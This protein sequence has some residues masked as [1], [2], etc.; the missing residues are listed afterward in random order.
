[1]PSI[2]DNFQSSSRMNLK[3]NSSPS[4][5]DNFN[6]SRSSISR[7]ADTMSSDRISS[8]NKPA[9]RTSGIT[10][11]EKLYVLTNFY[12]MPK[13][14]EPRMAYGKDGSTIYN[15]IGEGKNKY[16]TRYTDP[17]TGKTETSFV[18]KKDV[19]FDLPDV[20]KK[21]I[22]NKYANFIKSYVEDQN[23][24]TEFQKK[25]FESQSGFEKFSDLFGQ[26]Y[27]Q[28]L[29]GDPGPGFEMSTGSGV[30]DTVADLLAMGTAFGI[31][32]GS[33]AKSIWS[34]FSKVGEK[35]AEKLLPKA[36]EAAEEVAP[37]LSKE[38][39]KQ[40]GKKAARTAFKEGVTFG[41]MGVY[42]SAVNKKDISDSVRTVIGDF[43]LG[44]GFG[45][46]GKILGESFKLLKGYLK[47]APEELAKVEEPVKLEKVDTAAVK[48]SSPKGKY[49]VKNKGWEKA[50]NDYN[51]AIE[52]I[53]NHFRTNELRADEIP[54]I[55]KDLGIDMDKIISRMEKFESKTGRQMMQEAGKVS[56]SRRAAG[57]SSDRVYKI[58]EAI[59]GK[60]AK[61]AAAASAEKEAWQ[62]TKEEWR[63]V[64]DNG[65]GKK[66]MVTAATPTQKAL[67]ESV[68]LQHKTLVENAIK[69]NKAV[70]KNVAEE[71]PDLI[72]KYKVDVDKL[73]ADSGVMAKA[74]ETESLVKKK[75]ELPF[76]EGKGVEMVK[77]SDIEKFISD[78]LDIPVAQ[79]K[80]RQK[81]YGIFKVKPKVI[82]LK[83][84]K[85]L[86]T[87]YHETG[88]FLDDKLKLRDKGFDDELLKMGEATSRPD[89]TPD[90]KKAEGVAEFMRHYIV[91][92]AAAVKQAP[93]FYE[94]FE[95]IVKKDTRLDGMMKTLKQAT[96][97]YIKQD[98]QSRL[99]SNVSI[100]K[101][102]LKKRTQQLKEAAGA[103][104]EKLYVLA[105]EELKPLQ[106]VV[107]EITGGTKIS[108]SENPFE[109][110]WLNRGWQGRAEA[111]LKFGRVDKNFKKIGKSFEEIIKPVTKELDDFRAYA[112]AKRAKELA[113]REI[114]TGIIKSD[115][116]A[117][118]KRH[119]DKG[120]DKVLD[121]LVQYQDDVL[122]EL[123][124]QGVLSK[125]SVESMRI[126]NKDY[127]PFNRVMEQFQKKA[128]TGKG[129]QAYSPVKGIKGSTRDIIDPLESI[130][131]N[132]YVAIN[133]AERNRV[134]KALV[135]LG[136]KFEGVGKFFDKV[137]PKMMGQTIQLKDIEAALRDAGADTATINLE[138][139]ANIFRPNRFVG[140]D[141]IITVFR[142]GKP[143]YYEVFDEPLY[144]AMLALD[145]E[146]MNTLTKLLS[147]PA[148]ILRAGATLT[149]EFVARNPLRDTLSAFVYS[150]YGFFPIYDTARGLFH[151][152]K[153][154]DLYLKWISSGGAN[155]MFVSMDRDYLQKNLRGMLKTSLKDK[156]L[157]IIT[158]PLDALRAFSEF[159]EIAT[160]LGE[161]GKGVTKEGMT[162]EGIRKAALASR[163]I[164]LDF[165][166]AG[167]AGKQ[168]NKVIAFFNASLQSTDKL[169]REF[170]P[171]RIEGKL[172]WSRP[173]RNT[174]KAMAGITLPSILLY[175]ANKDDKRYQELP[176]WQK[177]TFWIILG[178]EK[179]YRIPKPFELG[180]IFGTI[181]ERILQ[182]IEQ[183]DK[184]AFDGIGQ[185][186][187]ETFVPDVIPTAL[188]PLIEAWTNYS[189]FKAGPI[190]TQ[191]ESNMEPWAQ[192]NAYTSETAKL[193]GKALNQ[194]PKIIEN[195]INGYGAGV[196]KY[197]LDVSDLLL[198][199]SGM[200]KAGTLPKATIE[201]YPLF[202]GFMTKAY[203]SSDSVDKFYTRLDA[204]EAEY[205]TAKNNKILFKKMGELKQLRSK[206]T[207]IGDIRKKINKVYA[208]TTYSSEKK[209]ELIDSYTVDMIN[210][211]RIALG[212]DTVKKGQ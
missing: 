189:F 89:Y 31:S 174:T 39:I 4:I 81:A 200:V 79:G 132:T 123:V 38:F 87:L 166:R 197:G 72:E 54:L 201:Q 169:I 192:F 117:I 59:G 138:Q 95:S 125:E 185:R 179:I 157:N 36:A 151:A 83:Q 77:R 44:A 94:Y 65:A 113:D 7:P 64:G 111:F 118:L 47:K 41:T 120:Y 75:I 137:P 119:A 45:A 126:L 61:P 74:R 24:V 167:T 14:I 101:F 37:K 63:Q 34:G 11:G 52:K 70:F 112:I 198:K 29:V 148:K 162:E 19:D 108:S 210:Q 71:Y 207:K 85:D 140:K 5:F 17:V 67:N 160:R 205:T 114:E 56:G 181:P 13:E 144:R 99:L 116:D 209:M 104:P 139:V 180:I 147:F 153:K 2:F 50:A 30:A 57:L 48:A 163:D 191:S 105:I 128:G 84:T 190:V 98:P 212:K 26:K 178:K 43:A 164:T 143:E 193:L 208:S 134:G 129:Y 20:K 28:A 96:E 103:A 135:Q 22:T 196:A 86:E 206:K 142:E 80:F 150:K 62:M 156:A 146:S 145:K 182:W 184:Q 176:Q 6:S 8:V 110:A 194:S 27:R 78:S 170:T 46:G 15:V 66:Y 49:T 122:S 35:A 68:D 136:E 107:E 106:R 32:P 199:A 130:I 133:M 121:Q 159:T 51:E 171:R 102:N 97:N 195:T 53:H 3:R 23:A 109:L 55:K 92:P 175:Y 12:E 93:K 25:K 42:D 40:T 172:D 18:A 188:M 100:G 10:L 1:M 149:P 186:L 161:F 88:H 152:I 58:M 82:R 60:E 69:E 115:V 91:D 173:L 158:H 90:M 21:E 202:K 73:P 131:K 124:S 155:S 16:Y 76:E 141:N 177:D 183:N 154:D 203:Q 211:A 165:G 187:K 33:G 127:I 204:L 9:G 168:I